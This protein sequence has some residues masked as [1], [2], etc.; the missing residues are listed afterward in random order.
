MKVLLRNALPAHHRKSSTGI[1][2]VGTA[3]LLAQ[4]RETIT[5]ANVSPS[6]GSRVELE[7]QKSD[8]G[9][10]IIMTISP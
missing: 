1:I 9:Q 8:S 7:G 10:A 4:I 6:N 3:P 2:L 5:S